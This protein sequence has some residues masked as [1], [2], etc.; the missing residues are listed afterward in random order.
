MKEEWCDDII[1]IER[2]V[3][4]KQVNSSLKVIEHIKG[5]HSV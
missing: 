3:I 2:T 4:T 1:A 5:G